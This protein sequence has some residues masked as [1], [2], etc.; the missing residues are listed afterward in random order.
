MADL[1]LWQWAVLVV[2][3][4]AIGFAKTAINGAGALAVVVFAWILPARESTGVILP[5]LLVADL[6]AV[7]V[8]RAHADWGLLARMFPWVAVGVGVGA[9]FVAHADDRT[10]QVTIGTTLLVLTGLQAVRTVQERRSGVAAARPRTAPAR[11]GLAAGTGILAGITTMVANAAGA[12]VSIYF[13]LS[14]LAMLRFLGTGAWFFLVVNLFKVPFSVS[15]GL[16]TWGDLVLDLLLVPPV[17]LGAWVGVATIR[18]I[19]QDHFENAT[20]ALVAVAA[21]LL[22][23]V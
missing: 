6:M 5:L 22:L 20:L 3:A 10:M 13:L 4:L 14:G 21:V 11:H 18:R 16:L 2:A 1:L 15:L 23:L 9:V 7:A 8:Y 19:D 17:G 12:V